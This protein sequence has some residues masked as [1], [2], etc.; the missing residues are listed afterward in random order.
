MKNLTI[1]S[2]GSLLL[3]A[4]CSPKAIISNIPVDNGTWKI[5]REMKKNK[6]YEKTG[7]FIYPNLGTEYTL[8]K[9]KFNGA[10]KIF[11]KND[12]LFY[13]VYKDNLPIGRYVKKMDDNQRRRHY[14]T[15]PVKPH[16][17]YGEGSGFFTNSHKKD[18]NWTED[19]INVYY[20]NG[21]KDSIR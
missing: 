3:L 10:F 21:I 7:T 11:D 17:D 4:N 18:G 16:L 1:F 14:R 19:G 8:K 13:C 9:G 12:T 2:L 6:I 5:E 20:R 15:I